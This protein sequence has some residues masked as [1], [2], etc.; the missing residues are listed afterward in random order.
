[1]AHPADATIAQMDAQH[2]RHTAPYQLVGEYGEDVPVVYVGWVMGGWFTRW[3]LKRLGVQG[4]M[5]IR[6]DEDKAWVIEHCEAA[7]DVFV[8]LLR[9]PSFA[10]WASLTFSPVERL[11]GD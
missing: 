4:R 8:R 11:P 5:E 2:A 3:R 7:P 6:C 10:P 1:M 9:H